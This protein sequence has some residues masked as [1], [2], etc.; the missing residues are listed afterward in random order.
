L[1]RPVAFDGAQYF[2]LAGF[3]TN[4]GQVVI[5]AV[6]YQIPEPSSFALLAF[7]MVSAWLFRR[8][9]GGIV[10]RRRAIETVRLAKVNSDSISTTS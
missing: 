4:G 3:G 7:G 2:D 9:R 8:N 5:D 10:I 6:L 1:A